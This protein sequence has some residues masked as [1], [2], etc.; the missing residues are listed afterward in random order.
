MHDPRMREHALPLSLTHVHVQ[1]A[2]A[3]RLLAK[4]CNLLI[5]GR[6]SHAFPPEHSRV[7]REK[8]LGCKYH[9]I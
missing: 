2:L 4:G 3:G 8:C 7:G 1:L 6:I 5:V 9:A